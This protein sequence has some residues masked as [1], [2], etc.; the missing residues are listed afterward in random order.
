MISEKHVMG[1][2]VVEYQPIGSN[3]IELERACSGSVS[4]QRQL[5]PEIN[6]LKVER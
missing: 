3:G 4:V 6:K 2:R 1:A 5:A